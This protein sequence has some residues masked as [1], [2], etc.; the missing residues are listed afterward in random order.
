MFIFI[1]V[2]FYFEPVVT[3]RNHIMIA[4]DVAFMGYG[5][6]CGVEFFQGWQEAYTNGR[7]QDG[8]APSLLAALAFQHE[9]NEEHRQDPISLTG[10]FSSSSI[11]NSLNSNDNEIF[12][13]QTAEY[14]RDL[15][16]ITENTDAT[17]RDASDAGFYNTEENNFICYQGLQAERGPNGTFSQYTTNTGHLGMLYWHMYW[18]LLMMKY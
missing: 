7:R 9:C 11:L 18:F 14:Y 16:G 2:T 3:E 5:G 8:S 1:L 13:Y 17:T 10:K 6:G 15:M 4:R 12:H